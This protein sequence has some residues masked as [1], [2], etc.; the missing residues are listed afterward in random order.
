MAG[1]SRDRRIRKSASVGRKRPDHRR[2]VEE[3][4]FASEALAWLCGTT[5]S[6]STAPIFAIARIK[7]VIEGRAP[8]WRT[9]RGVVFRL[10]SRVRTVPSARV[11]YGLGE[12]LAYSHM[13]S[14]PVL[15]QLGR[16]KFKEVID[17]L[18]QLEGFARENT[19]RPTFDDLTI[20]ENLKKRELDVQVFQYA[21]HYIER[22]PSPYRKV[23]GFGAATESLITLYPRAFGQWL[24]C[25]PWGPVSHTVLSYVADRLIF[26]D[27]SD[28][29]PARLVASHIPLLQAMVGTAQVMTFFNKAPRS[30]VDTYEW[31]RSIGASEGVSYL[32]AL[33]GLG[34]P[35]HDRRVAS[36]KAVQVEQKFCAAAL[37]RFADVGD[38]IDGGGPHE[39][40]NKNLDEAEVELA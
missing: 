26:T 35:I 22:Q 2:Q 36:N 9:D 38:Q 8:N 30:F 15:P 33:P 29:F 6:R 1:I 34:P 31:C 11:I 7:R 40:P 19:P 32:I 25:A 20:S 16:L 28:V 14:A 17:L 39:L 18:A 10:I 37:N 3:L 5:P 13:G 23:F 4:P 12:L 27:P 24:A 21:R